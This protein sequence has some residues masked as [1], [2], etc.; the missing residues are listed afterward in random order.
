MKKN[1]LKTLL[2]A[3]VFVTPTGFTSCT[4]HSNQEQTD[5]TDSILE[6]NVRV[7]VPTRTRDGLTVYQSP[8]KSALKLI[9]E[10]GNVY[11]SWYDWARDAGEYGEE[12]P[13]QA[14]L[15]VGEEEGWYRVETDIRDVEGYVPKDECEVAN[16]IP[17][18]DEILKD[19]LEEDDMMDYSLIQQVVD[20]VNYHLAWMNMEIEDR[21]GYIYDLDPTLRLYKIEDGKVLKRCIKF[22]IN[23]DRTEITFYD[24]YDYDAKKALEP[25]VVLANPVYCKEGG[26]AEMTT[27]DL[28]KIVDVFGKKW[29]SVSVYVEGV[30]LF[31][32]TTKTGQIGPTDE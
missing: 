6:T 23:E 3:I 2:A 12:S 28:K 7:I 25:N 11:T 15:V 26:F 4:H 20:G 10:G 27:E 16:L 24:D 19:E 13:Y 29:P 18:T 1:I 14:L 22:Q 5:A 17:V 32:I 31:D 30:G 8:S 21:M 9:C